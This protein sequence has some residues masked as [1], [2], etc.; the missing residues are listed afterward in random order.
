MT[1][2]TK[3]AAKEVREFW[4]DVDRLGTA[5]VAA[6]YRWAQQ[7]PDP[8]QPS[9]AFLHE[10]IRSLDTKRCVLLDEIVRLSDQEPSPE[11]AAAVAKA[12]GETSLIA[13]ERSAA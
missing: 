7:H 1:T 12:A 10:F 9:S 6:C 13:N 3:S 2:S 5:E 11:I 4:A 8:A